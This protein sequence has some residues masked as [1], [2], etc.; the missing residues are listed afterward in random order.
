MLHIALMRV[1]FE[2][3][4]KT[5][6]APWIFESRS[7]FR[8]QTSMCGRHTVQSCEMISAAIGELILYK[9]SLAVIFHGPLE[10]S[11]H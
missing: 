9:T 1:S 4:L 8:N 5:E 2:E 6:I 7:C 10:I 11:F 3:P